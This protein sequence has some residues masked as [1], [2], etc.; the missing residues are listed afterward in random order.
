M[1]ELRVIASFDYR[2]LVTRAVATG[3]KVAMAIQDDDEG[4][5]E[6]SGS[7]TGV[8]HGPVHHA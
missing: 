4:T 6:R 7:A 5:T 1:I 2:D 3:C 8:G